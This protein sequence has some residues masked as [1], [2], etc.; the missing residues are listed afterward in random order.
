MTQGKCVTLSK[1]RKIRNAMDSRL[2]ELGFHAPLRPGDGFQ[3]TAVRFVGRPTGDFFWP[4]FGYPII[5]SE[6]GEWWINSK[7]LGATLLRVD[8]RTTE[9]AS[10]ERLAEIM[11]RGAEALVTDRWRPLEVNPYILLV[12]GE[13]GLPVGSRI[14]RSCEACGYQEIEHADGSWRLSDKNIPDLDVFFIKGT[15][16]PVIS[17]AVA[18]GLRKLGSRLMQL[19]LRALQVS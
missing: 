19:E 13:S 3:P 17:N 1:F 9:L 5:S 11:G 18:E 16:I 10:N 12:V 4:A 6:L 14:V 2:T 7:W 15:Q 8:A